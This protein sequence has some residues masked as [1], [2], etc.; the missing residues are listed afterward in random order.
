[1]TLSSA[2]KKDRKHARE[3]GGI[4]AA[5]TKQT[6]GKFAH[7]HSSVNNANANPNP[8]V[9]NKDNANINNN[10]GGESKSSSTSVAS[11]PPVDT[12]EIKPSSV[13]DNVN[14]A[15]S[16]ML[17]AL[18][19]TPASVST[20]PSMNNDWMRSGIAGSPG[21]LISIMGD[22]PPTQPSSYE[23]SGRLHHGWA[24]QRP[25]MS[26]SPS[27]LSPPNHGRRP[28]S[29][30]MDAQYQSPETP[31]L[32]A[33]Y[34]R[35]SVASPFTGSR[36]GNNPPL[37]HQPQAHFYG[38]PDIDLNL[39]NSSGMKAGERGYFFGF[40]K[41]PECPDFPS[42]PSNAVIAGYEGGLDVYAVGKRG[43]EPVASLKGLRGGVYNA[44]ILPWTLDNSNKSLFPLVAVVL[45]GPVLPTGTP[46]SA[47]GEQS[48]R[49]DGAASPRS[50][51]THP[52]GF[53]GRH[54]ID[55][56]QTSVEIY[57][58]KTNQLIDVLLQAPKIQINPEISVTN[59]IFRP[60][61]P[62]GSFTIRADSGTLA[63]CSGDTGECWVYL[64]LLEEQNGHVFT[65][66]GKIWTSLQQSTRVEVQEETD[67]TRVSSAPPRSN[68]QTP[69][70][71]ISGRWISY[72][73][74]TPSSQISLNAHVPLPILGKAPGLATVTPPQLPS[75]SASVDLPISDSVVNKIMR[76]TTQEL[77]QGARWVGQQSLQAW[78]SYW[79]KSSPQSQTQ[80]ARSPPQGW[81]GTRSPRGDSSQFP[82][83][84]GTNGQTVA[85]DPGLISI[86]D[87]ESLP[88]SSSIHPITTFAP[89]LGCSFLSF[90]PSSL[91]LF[92]ASSKGD[93]Q[94]VWD[95]FRIQHTR[96]SPLQATL[97]PNTSTGPQVR[98]IA[99]F[100][101]MTV[102]RIVDVA[103][104]QSQ[105]E[106]LAMVTE[107]G[108]VH[109]L[110]MPS[111]AFMWPAPRRRQ[112]V[113]E[114]GTATPEQP[115]TAVSL[116][117]GAFGA[118]YQAAKPFVSRPRRS[119]GNVPNMP[120]NSLKDSA[121]I[122]GRVIAASISSSLGKTGTAINQLRHTGEN[123]V[124]LPL[125]SNLPSASCVTWVRSRRHQGL[126]VVGNGLVRSFSCRTRRSSVQA[127]RKVT[128]ASRY[129]DHN[130]P[131]LPSDLVAPAVRQ[132]VDLGAQDEIL[133]LSDRDM[134]AGNTL[135]LN[136]RP[137]VASADHNMESSIPQAEIESSAPYQPFHTDRRVT[138]C[139]YRRGTTDQL[140]VVSA[141]L[142][143]TNLE[144]NTTSKKKKKKGQPMETYSSREMSSTTAWAFGQDIPVVR[145]DLGLPTVT[146]EEYDGP[147]DH[148]ALPPS[149][150]ERVM[151]YG[152][153]A[154]IVVTTRR[155]RG[156][157]GGSQ[158]E[159][160]FFEDDCEV[161]DFADQRV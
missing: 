59:P 78:N 77:I 98:Q 95:L 122:G 71:A 129:H 81:A 135:T 56:Y 126:F 132:M 107:R 2:S 110:D 51:F 10:N 33:H 65:C 11:T 34:R 154:Q 105:G 115:N 54:S 101:R 17:A 133:D 131:N 108:T 117:T 90:S 91:A 27:S 13:P 36:I 145:L 52:E 74:A 70:L 118:A 76:E 100:S 79:N 152:D 41:L 97:S 37:P 139:E 80:Q 32:A 113:Q 28:L 12:P 111:S 4:A 142:A 20:A 75:S 140:E 94:T 134:D 159:D 55:A 1:M 8:N 14:P 66:V 61:A 151:Q 149:A 35:S 72:C 155:R 148:I 86:I 38:T 42:S 141:I 9:N 109:L 127:G 99:Q 43:L 158:G 130:V 143:D 47:Q 153:E 53:Q 5:V 48:P 93:V 46:G 125:S 85:K 23:D 18:S 29:F 68:P 123:R 161:L 16:P 39:T 88:A 96:S 116:A 31:P 128:R 82:P 62:S 3:S 138:L 44:K 137:R 157:Q 67:K 112:A 146:E 73:P 144:E 40:D 19:T 64:Q 102:A 21:N 136:A 119:S 26:P 22:S 150:M 58:L 63:V 106:R 92:T 104:T 114:S 87:T 57:S 60:P 83:T 49:H 124:S 24:V 103:W 15:V 69:I 156:A 6:A 160:G 121:A 7:I 30:Q 147:E 89:P 25:Y 45:H 84:H 120:G 50:V